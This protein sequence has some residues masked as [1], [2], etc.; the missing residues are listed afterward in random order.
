MD[1]GAGVVMLV[2]RK[3]EVSLLRE[4]Y[5]ADESKLVAV[6]GR[7]RVGKTYLIRETFNRRFTFQHTGY[8][9]GTTKEE[10]FVFQA[11]L[12]EAGLDGF[13]SPLNWLE[14]FELLKDLI[15]SST[16]ERKVIFID[17]LSWMDTGHGDLMLALEGFWNGWAS[18]RTDI[19]LI[20]CGSAT[21][22]ML[23]K[24][25]H[26]KGGLYNRL[27]LQINLEP[28]T[29]AQCEEYATSMGIDMNRHQLLE[30]YMIMGG[31]PFYWG[32][33]KK[34]LSLA[35]N[36]D[37]IF[38]AR[39]APLKDESKYLYASLFKHPENHIAII[40]ALGRRR[41]G[42]ERRELL[43]ATGMMNSGGFTKKLEELEA[44]G[45]IRRY[46]RYGKRSRNSLYQLTDNFTLFHLKFMDPQPTDEHYWEHQLT[47]P[48]RNAWAGLAFERV[49][50]Q[51]VAQ[52]KRALG[53]SGVLTEVS[54]W[55][56][57]ANENEG[58]HGSQV[59]LVIARRD[60]VIDLCETKYSIDEYVITKKVDEGLRRKASD[61]RR[62]TKTR[63]AVHTVIVT[64]YGVRHN[65]YWGNIQ[66]EVTAADLFA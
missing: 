16:D 41:P 49:C 38:F 46:H 33:L 25:V 50:L 12:R 43:E 9:N 28:F 53:I 65:A 45:F 23:N 61:F 1:E 66:A 20:I 40:S 48:Q 22:W 31:I 58:I 17:E 30:C 60:Q 54:S 36:V 10:L 44:C 47:A 35:Q 2:A 64:T 6:Y 15:R 59:D 34:G 55:S 19:L 29:L 18:S 63:S 27:S 26:N 21:S 56:C 32:F 7:R 37:A 13:E 62:V 52:I 8:A 14:A 57:E 5:E 4:A 24:V 3:G 39:N 42:M 11:S 51:H